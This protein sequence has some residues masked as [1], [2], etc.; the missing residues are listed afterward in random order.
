MQI[1]YENNIRIAT[2][3]ARKYAL[4]ADWFIEVRARTL[5]SGPAGAFAMARGFTVSYYNEHECVRATTT[6]L[7]S[8]LCPFVS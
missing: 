8:P 5:G 6:P 1:L 3:S 4:R 2:V 7:R